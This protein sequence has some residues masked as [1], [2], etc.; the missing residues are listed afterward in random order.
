[1]EAGSGIDA[2]AV[3]NLRALQTTAARRGD[4]ALSVYASLLEALTYLKAPKGGTAERVQSCLAHV[5]KYQLDPSVKIM[6]VEVLALLLDVAANLN[7]QTPEITADKLRQL[8]K[9]LSECEEW[10]NVKSEF[11]IPIRRSATSAK[12]VSSD[13]AAIIYEREGD[14][15]SEFLIVSFMTKVEFTALV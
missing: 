15:S 9:K 2:S 7:S 12:T 4:V 13:T 8:Q 5:A 6:Q 11:A 3:D 14:E 10:H 1:M